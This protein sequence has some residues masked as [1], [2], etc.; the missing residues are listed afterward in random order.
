MGEREANS[1]MR[2]CFSMDGI[3]NMNHL[4]TWTVKH[5]EEFGEF[6]EENYH[7]DVYCKTVVADVLKDLTASEC[8][9]Q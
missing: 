7:G 6:R 3:K 4:Y 8:A 5:S 1:R 9:N 2:I